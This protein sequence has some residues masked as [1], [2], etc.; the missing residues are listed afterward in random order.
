MSAENSPLAEYANFIFKDASNADS[1][2]QFQGEL[3]ISKEI[4]DKI[5]E[6]GWEHAEFNHGAFSTGGPINEQIF[7]KL[8][9]IGRLYPTKEEG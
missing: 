4:L 7:V 8:N 6:I 1:E 5:N 3:P 9:R 2:Q